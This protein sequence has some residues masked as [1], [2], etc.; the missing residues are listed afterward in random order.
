M[1]TK[2]GCHRTQEDRTTKGE[3]KET[4]T[5]THNNIDINVYEKDIR[6]HCAGGSKPYGGILLK[7]QRE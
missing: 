7:Q 3:G 4:K 1:R 2:H 6:E 5:I